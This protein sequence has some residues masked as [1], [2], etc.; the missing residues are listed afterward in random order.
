MEL[1]LASHL[2]SKNKT[3]VN[4][5]SI[6]S[7]FCRES[8]L[9]IEILVNISPFLQSHVDQVAALDGSCGSA[10]HNF[11]A[12]ECPGHGDLNKIAFISVDCCSDSLRGMRFT[13]KE[14]ACGRE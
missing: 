13:S 11:D 4:G 14:I 10:P 3:G 2:V 7:I 6:V 5:N 12:L 8:W 1:W 9:N